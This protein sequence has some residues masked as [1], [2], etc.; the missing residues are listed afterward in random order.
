MASDY[1]QKLT[2]IYLQ[3]FFQKKDLPH[4]EWKVISNGSV[5]TIDN[6]RVIRSILAAK[7]AE[8]GLIAESLRELDDHDGDINIFLKQLA[9]QSYFMR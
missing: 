4:Q 6:K 2:S 7:P 3:K 5:Y 1:F 8:Q 9:K